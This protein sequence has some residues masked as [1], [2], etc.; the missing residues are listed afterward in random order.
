MNY[1]SPS[2][3][4]VDLEVQYLYITLSPCCL[5]N[6]MQNGP[7]P[8][9]KTGRERKVPSTVNPCPVVKSLDIVTKENLTAENVTYSLVSNDFCQWIGN[10]IDY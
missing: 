8:I 9:L 3:G 4:S 2:Y 10:T 7:A 6:S 1:R 5:K